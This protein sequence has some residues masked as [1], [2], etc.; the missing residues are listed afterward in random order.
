M[1]DRASAQPFHLNQGE[2]T[3]HA[4]VLTS[5]QAGRQACITCAKIKIK[6]VSTQNTRKA[7]TGSCKALHIMCSTRLRCAR[8][9]TCMNQPKASLLR[10][11]K[12]MQ[13]ILQSSETGRK[14][15]REIMRQE[16][17]IL[18]CSFAVH[19][20]RLAAVRQTPRMH[21]DSVTILSSTPF[22]RSLARAFSSSM[23]KLRLFYIFPSI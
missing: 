2:G 19:L 10:G 9:G 17:S 1:R 13:I 12:S 21:G 23:V 15:A 22:S 20:R 16:S 3:S 4:V 5:R 7:A 14:P 18:C 8:V 11:P 6:H